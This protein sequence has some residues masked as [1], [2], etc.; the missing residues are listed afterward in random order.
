MNHGDSD[1]I[2]GGKMRYA[3]HIPYMD[4][5]FEKTG[6]TEN[7]IFVLHDW[8]AA[9]GFYRACR[10]S[11]Q[12]KGIAYLE[13]MVR[14]RFWSDMPDERVVAFKKMRGPEGDAMIMETNFFVEKMLFEMGTIRD[15]TEEEKNVYR[16]PTEDTQK[17]MQ[18][19]QWPREIPFEGE[20]E[21]NYK[22]VKR[23]SD[24]LCAN[25]DLPKLF[26]NC[27]EGHALAGAAREFCRKWPNQTEITLK[28][29]HYAQEDCPGEIG[30]AVAGFVKKVR[31]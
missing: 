16:K 4:D 30:Q 2:P 3:D 17:R 7:A 21:D 11:G 18:T 15:L 12:V 29:R 22:L 10:F 5:W 26:I 1:N 9:L 23:Y 25:E 8:G 19:L 6:A 28:A 31:G 24:F 20:P 14:P 13:S 27:L